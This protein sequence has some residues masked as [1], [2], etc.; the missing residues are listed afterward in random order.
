MHL[1]DGQRSGKGQDGLAQGL[2]IGLGAEHYIGGVFPPVGADPL[3]GINPVRARMV[4]DASAWIRS[5]CRATAGL[6]AAPIWLE[7]D[8]VLGQL[9]SDRRSRQEQHARFVTEGL[10]E[11]SPQ[12]NA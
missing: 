6:A 7:T 4:A 8:S 2:E 10:L 9:G 3:R 12:D 5:S 1:A 11:A